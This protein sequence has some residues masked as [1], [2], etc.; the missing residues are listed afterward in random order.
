MIPKWRMIPLVAALA[1]FVADSAW[2]MPL[3]SRNTRASEVLES[4][5]GVR[6]RGSTNYQGRGNI[7]GQRAAAAVQVPV[8]PWVWEQ[9]AVFQREG[10]TKFLV[11]MEN[12]SPETAMQYGDGTTEAAGMSHGVYSVFRDQSPMYQ[13][14]QVVASGNGFEALAEDGNVRPL[15]SFLEGAPSSLESGIF[16]KPV[17]AVR[18]EELWPGKIY[19]FVVTADPGDQLTFATMLM[20]SNDLV[21]APASGSIALF[22]REGRPVSGDITPQ[23]ALL[24]AGTEVNE[25]PGFGVCSGMNQTTLNEGPSESL[26]VE[27]VNDGYTYPSVAEVLRVTI[28]PLD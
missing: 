16:Y 4:E 28:V 26:P 10:S 11:R 14:G 2:A 21:Y 3:Q 18:D 9:E 5:S 15:Q 27:P 25:E 8:Y 6:A 17:G 24:D 1:G 20:Q 12:I 22:D 23:L 13:V 19:E 7:R